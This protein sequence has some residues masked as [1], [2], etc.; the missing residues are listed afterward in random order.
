LVFEEATIEHIRPR[1]EG[2]NNDLRN[3]E[4]ACAKCNNERSNWQSDKE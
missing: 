1:S 2:G 3:L 4:I